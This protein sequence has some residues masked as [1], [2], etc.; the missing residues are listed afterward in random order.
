MTEQLEAKSDNLDRNM[1][2]AFCFIAFLFWSAFVGK[3]LLDYHSPCADRCAC[4]T[5]D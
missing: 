4:D 2:L 3:A 5:A 1:M